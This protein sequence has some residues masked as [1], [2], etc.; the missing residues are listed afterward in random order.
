MTT[1]LMFKE[2]MRNS[3]YFVRVFGSLE[4]KDFGVIEERAL[5]TGMLYLHE[6]YKKAPTFDEVCLFFENTT[7]VNI[8]VKE[9]VSK[10]LI[11][12]KDLD[13]KVSDDILIE[14]TEAHIK[15]IRTEQML[16]RGIKII[17]GD[18]KETIE[19]IHE[20]MKNIISFSLSDTSGH[21]YM[22]DSMVRFTELGRPEETKVSSGIE[23][24]DR[25]GYGKKKSLFLFM[26][27]S[28]GGK[29]LNM[30]S[31]VTNAA[32]QGFNVAVFTFED[33]EIAWSSRIDCNLMNMP[34]EELQEKGISVNT[35]FQS[36]VLDKIGKIKLKEFPTGGANANNIRNILRDWKSKDD[37]IPDIIMVDYIGIVGPVSRSVSN[38]YEKGK[39]VAEEIRALSVEY[40]VPVVSAVQTGRQAF[41]AQ[42][43]SMSDVADSIGIIQTADTVVGII[44]DAETPDK[45]FNA[46]LKSR[47]I[48]KNKLKAE[49]TNVD[50]DHQRVTD[51]GDKRKARVTKKYQEEIQELNNVVEVS[52]SINDE[53]EDIADM[54]N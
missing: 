1:D 36:L 17:E 6:Q 15:T 50:T 9:A 51:I 14:S 40:N 30:A 25:A 32:I 43:L 5:F 11:A 44:V 31:C 19:D 24:F 47:Q 7:S 53:N 18:S 29:T 35:T 38:G 33:G 2:L 12:I 52:E 13:V 10:K 21:D 39:T 23:L 28:N 16:E 41:D 3:D 27:P 46:V 37:F 49:A 26:S 20:N 22:K 48:D 8:K 34:L 4:V 45:Q 42:K 54:F